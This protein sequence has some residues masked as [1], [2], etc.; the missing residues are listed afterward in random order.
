MKAVFQAS[1]M[2]AA[3]F[4]QCTVTTLTGALGYNLKP[5]NYK[6]CVLF[7]KVFYGYQFLLNGNLDS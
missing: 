4:K 7:R 1:L 2:L 6:T 5:M 3:N